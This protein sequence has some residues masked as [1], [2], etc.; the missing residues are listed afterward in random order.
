MLLEFTSFFFSVRWCFYLNEKR[1]QHYHLNHFT[2]QQII[3]LCKTMAKFL[4]ASSTRHNIAKDVI[5]LLESVNSNLSVKVV[6]DALEKITTREFA[7]QNETRSAK[8]GKIG[9]AQ[10]WQYIL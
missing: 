1:S 2:I 4:H 9:P 3:H 8:Q 6:Q 5:L 10:H 7:M